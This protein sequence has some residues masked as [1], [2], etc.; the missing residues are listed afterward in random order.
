MLCLRRIQSARDAH[1]PSRWQA[2]GHVAVRDA[3]DRRDL[4]LDHG[5]DV[6]DADLIG[7]AGERVAAVH[8]AGALDEAA[9]PQ[10]RGEL[11]EVGERQMLD[12]SHLGDAQRPGAVRLGEL[13]HHAQAV[14]SL[15]AHPHRERRC[16]RGAGI[17]CVPV[18]GTP[19]ELGRIPTVM[20]RIIH[21]AHGPREGMRAAAEIFSARPHAR[22]PHIASSARS[23]P[24]RAPCWPAA[25]DRRSPT[26]P[27]PTPLSHGADPGALHRRRQRATTRARPRSR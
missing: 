26:S 24:S 1:S 2:A 22:P 3:L 27:T 8:A 5:D 20:V 10:L 12:P 25:A 15:G 16:G 19:P 18:S 17:G 21:R 7:R 13:G 11:L 23:A 6:E 9:A 14:V 4:A